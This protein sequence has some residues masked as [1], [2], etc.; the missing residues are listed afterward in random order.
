MRIDLI[1]ILG[2]M[3]S[4]NM[5]RV[6]DWIGPGWLSII[7]IVFMVMSMIGEERRKQEQQVKV[8][9]ERMEEE[10]EEERKREEE[11]TG[12]KPGRYETREHYAKRMRQEGETK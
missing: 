12:P 9:R 4:D 2:D 7:F 5:N 3:G 1:T 11:P 8:M 10:E 6:A